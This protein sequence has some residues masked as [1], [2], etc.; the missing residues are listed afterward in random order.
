M[1]ES[2]SSSSSPDDRSSKGRATRIPLDYYKKNDLVGNLKTYITVIVGIILLVW[3]AR[4]ID[5]LGMFQLKEPLTTAARLDSSHGELSFNHSAWDAKC[6]ACHVS[7]QPIKGDHLISGAIGHPNA[8]NQ[9]CEAC[10][11]GPPHHLNIKESRQINECTACHSEHQGRNFSL[12]DL[13]DKTCT[14]CHANLAEALAAPNESLTEADKHI[15]KFSVLSHPE[16]EVVRDLDKKQPA[17]PSHLKF[18]HAV[19]MNLGM[20]QPEGKPF[21]KYTDIPEADRKQYVGGARPEDFVQLS[22]TNCHQLDSSGRIN[23]ASTNT[24]DG[25]GRNFLPI[26][27]DANCAACHALTVP[28][29][30]TEIVVNAAKEWKESAEQAHIAPSN[31]TI[32]VPHGIQPDRIRDYL[33]SIYFDQAVKND[34]ELSA[35]LLATV[36]MPG[37]KKDQA[38]KFKNSVDGQVA[39]AEDILYLGQQTC[40]KCHS[41]VS[42]DSK[43]QWFEGSRLPPDQLAS[44]EKAIADDQLK[45]EPTDLQAIWMPKAI[46]SH[47]SHRAVDCQQ[48]HPAANPAD[49]HRSISS[50]DIMLPGINNCVECHSPKRTTAN[51]T[52]GGVRHDC[53]DCHRYHQVNTVSHGLDTKS[54]E[55]AHRQ[56]IQ[57]FLSPSAKSP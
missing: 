53:V 46:F 20:A 43:T 12:V 14:Q 55:P 39:F 54:F 31:E 56:S 44:F 41:Y 30:P 40:S 32:N 18:N 13:K 24:I 17:D 9:K 1:P 48:C 11:A 15:D 7:F 51:G 26:S 23:S 27:F 10:H 19:H 8:V 36:D 42:T 49:T 4:S 35:D 52:V 34:K 29:S 47:K 57:E 33:Q 37:P 6:E 3:L 22:C 45:V 16:F 25:N 28:K 50:N 2:R 38:R 5:F 21:F